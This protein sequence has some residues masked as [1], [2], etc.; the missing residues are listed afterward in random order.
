MRQML[1]GNTYS[2]SAS[3][4]DSSSTSDNNLRTAITQANADTGTVADTINLSAGTYTLS[5]GQL[6]ITNTDH[7]LIIQG[8]GSSGPN[9]TIIDQTALDRVFEVS[10]A[11]VIF[12]N[13]EITGGT[14]ETDDTGSTSTQAEGGGLLDEG[15]VTLD[16]VAVIGNKAVGQG[17]AGQNAVGG[18]V[19]SSGVLDIGD[20][21]VIENN[22]AIAA[23]GV[24]ANPTNGAFLSMAE[25][26]GVFSNTESSLEISDTTIEGNIAQAGAG[27]ESA[28]GGST[29]G[30]GVYIFNATGAATSQLTDDT[31]SGNQAIAGAGGAGGPGSNGGQGGF[32]VGGGVEID[33]ETAN[34][35]STGSAMGGPASII[36]STISGN[37]VQGGA[38]G[39]A[40]SSGTV[41]D[42]GGGLGGGV[43]CTAADSEVL[44]D[45]IDGNSAL[46][47]NGETT[48]S[49]YGGGLDD[50]TSLDTTASGML[51]VSATFS[52][53]TAQ[54]GTAPAGGTTGSGYGGG[55]NN[56]GGDTLLQVQNTISA[57]N[58]ASTG[59][60]VYGGVVNT[61]DNVIGDGTDS[62]GFTTTNGD[63][64]GTS[65]SPLAANLGPLQNNG[66]NVNTV[67]LLT[68]SP[69]LGKGDPGVDISNN[70]TTDERGLSRV[71]AGKM[72]VGAFQ[73]QLQTPT[74]TNATTAAGTQTTSGLVITPAA[75]DASV[76]TSF[77]ITNI[78][79]GT[80][81]QHNGTTPI[82]DGD[83]ISVAQGAA[84]LK[85]TPTGSTAGGSFTVQESTSASSLGLGGTTATATIS[86][87]AHSPSVTGTA[88]TENT[89]TSSGL[90]ITP[91]AADTSVTFFQITGISGGTL[92]Q[93]N[94]TSQITNGDFITTAQAAAGLKFSPTTNSLAVGSFAVQESTSNSAGGLIGTTTTA[95]IP[96]SFNGPAVTGGTTTEGTQTTS[97]LVV[98]PGALDTATNFQVTGITGG[99]LYQN[100]GTT[101]IS[102]GS[103]ITLAQGA[104]GLKFTPTTGSVANG[105]FTVRESSDGTTTG[106][107][108]PTATAGITVAFNGPSVTSAA[109]TENTQTTSGLVITPGTNDTPTSF[110]IT[111]I[112]GGT[113]YQNDGTTVISNGAFITTAQ[114]AAGLKFT[115]T[116]GSVAAGLFTVRESS[117]GTVAG[118]SGPTAVAT[119]TLSNVAATAPTV[120]PAATTENTQTTSGLVLTPSSGVTTYF[121]ITNITGGTLYQNDGTTQI[122]SGSF[123]TLAQGEAGLKFTPTTGSTATGSFEAQEATGNS[124]GDLTGSTGTGTIFVSATASATMPTVTPA[125]TTENTQ[126]TSGLVITPSS[127]ATTNFQITNITGGTL[128][129]NDGTT[130][131]T[132]GSFITLA[133][134]EA[135]L[136]FTP[137]SGSLTTGSFDVQEATG[138]SAG[139]LTGTTA[140][141]TIFVTSSTSNAPTVTPATTAENTQTTSGLV[142]GTSSS[143]VTYFQITGITGGTLYQNDGATQI[144][145]GQ[146]ITLAQGQAGVKFT[147]TTGS[148]ANGTFNVQQATGNSAG[149][150][151][152]STAAATITVGG[153]A[154]VT[155]AT[156]TQNTQTTSGLVITPSSGSITDFEITGITGGTLYQND[157]A[158]QITNGSFITV[159][160]G[161]AGLK[162]T[163]TTGSVAN[164]SFVVQQSTSSSSDGLT[165]PTVTATISVS[166]TQAVDLSTYYN[167][168]G[169]TTDGTNFGTGIDGEGDAL[170][171]TEV[172]TSITWNGITFALGSPNVPDVIQG[173]GQTIT[174]SSGSYASVQLLAVGTNGNQ[175]SQQFVVNYS[176]GTSTTV[177]Q[178]I[179]DWAMPQGYPGESVALTTLYRNTSNGGMQ[180]GTFDVYGYSIAVDPSKTVES[181]TLPDNAKVK[182]LSIAT[183]AAV[184]APSNL[185]ATDASATQ[186]N[187]SWTASDSTVTGY[188]VYRSTTSGAETTT[189]INSS[190]LSPTAT[191]YQDTSVLAGNTYYYT[192]KAVNGTATSSA[193]NEATVTVTS[194][195][196]TTE[197]DLAGLYNLTGITDDGSTFGSGFDGDGNALSETQVG[198]SRAWNGV[199]FSIAPAGG[200]NV[201]QATGQTLDLPSGSYS[202]VDLLAAGVNGNQPSQTFTVNYTDGT[203]TTITQSI[204][205]WHMPQAYSGE[206]IVLSSPYRNTSVGGRDNAGPFDVYGYSFAVDSAKTVA[207]ITLPDNTNVEVLSISMVAGVAAPTDLTATAESTTEVN[208]SWTAAS[209]T[210]TGYNVYRGTTAGGESTTPLNSSPLAATATSYSDTTAVAGNT[211]FYVVKAVNTPAVS[212]A[213]NEATA[214]AL[215]SDDTAAQVDLSGEYNLTGITANGTTFA[216]GLDGNGNALSATL[217]GT[218]QTWNGATFD[219]GAA[220]SSNVVQATGQTVGL[221][222]G[223]YS[224]VELLA[225]GVNGNQPPQTFTVNYTDGTS[226]AFARSISDW[227]TPQNN[228]GEATA[229]TMAYRNTSSGGQFNST[230]NVYGYTLAVDNTKTIA[231]ITLPDNKNVEILAI[232]AA[233]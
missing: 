136:K 231:S 67:A 143:S 6:D 215:I 120:T 167:V 207:S 116:T 172:G 123:I 146:F 200:N 26:G 8:Q 175:P 23:A 83:F 95:T 37:T 141:A 76:V 57:A 7:A 157:G 108:G 72:D 14:A 44:N 74:V 45:T 156:T 203:S 121:Q 91:N 174:L 195:A 102:N 54:P 137:T 208:L 68:G 51:V 182:V 211:Y 58:T 18:G 232:T 112:S 32:A 69:A 9:A 165:G 142:I 176:D 98:T 202:Q 11:R 33:F 73:T 214:T 228:A 151:I 189:P 12:K 46:G 193:S 84:G 183:V 71:V 226:T 1:S 28:P 96:V 5:L 100:D 224:Q 124:A 53:N 221:P 114:G 49:G 204:S 55:I 104:A 66:G 171:E 93:N 132:S 159:A 65:G 60:D 31:I 19:F 213:S 128:Y 101:V 20:G 89:Q 4:A 35:S 86:V 106:L 168:T 107:S 111:G 119:I 97:G 201:I 125:A 233:P 205:D 184:D 78:T 216:G 29:F 180:S 24:L 218:T 40:G 199:T 113:L 147:P 196:A 197:V 154:T 126:T 122:T 144:T 145:N 135:G 90:V 63:Q 2:P 99:T 22:S 160:Q 30:G 206:S 190:P 225:T 131:I 80:L 127:G 92:Y 173:T 177:T 47:G 103:F 105:S 64:V 70:I 21:S 170:S 186:V 217:L 94:G 162:F 13:V 163:P 148:T 166:G 152:G 155:G 230:F 39:A 85:F 115:P 134:G 178:S 179:S 25:G 229:V 212:A 187:L 3:V 79:G 36:N 15:D 140:A 17:T 61:D 42:G 138:S 109:T 192:V 194:A 153:G 52:A 209:G 81:Y 227:A 82:S 164:G 210:V 110:Q 16:N 149:D 133:Q 56:Y 75:S 220:G 161:A 158:T 219:I 129:Q 198:T 181:I 43:D 41:G 87:T 130:Q 222:N 38:G 118:L 62:S 117:D 169:I 150:L 139:D 88:T 48:G 34:E 27:S 185:T 59:P 188:D 77:Q 50:E 191:S 223:E 10:G